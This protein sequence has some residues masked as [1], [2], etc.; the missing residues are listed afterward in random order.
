MPGCQTILLRMRRAALIRLAVAIVVASG[1]V[2][3]ATL[4][5]P[6]F[7]A[8]SVPDLLCQLVLL[9]GKLLA[10]PFHDRGTASPEF[11]WRSRL[12]GTLL[13]TGFAFILLRPR[14]NT[15]VTRLPEQTPPP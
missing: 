11:L 4:C 14:R 10:T 6:E 5:Q 13:L 8:G 2:G 1:L 12:F 3:L 7:V 9:P 15:S